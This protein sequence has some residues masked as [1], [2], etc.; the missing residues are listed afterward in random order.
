MSKGNPFLA[1]RVS[2]DTLARLRVVSEQCGRAVSDT[3]REALV[4][5]LQAEDGNT[6]VVSALLD[7]RRRLAAQPASRTRKPTRHQRAAA[8]TTEL[9]QLL[10]EYSDWLGSLPDFAEG[11]ATAAKL[12]A[13]IEALEAALE[14]LEELDLPR[15]YGRD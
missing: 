9:R 12:E 3:A 15:G 11:T 8:A 4:R 2:P 14:A 13:A 7:D 6:A 5:G 1:L 10:D